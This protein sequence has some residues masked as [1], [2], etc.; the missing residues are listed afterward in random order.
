MPQTERIPPHAEAAEKSVLGSLLIDK[1][2]FF[3]VSDKIRPDD[4]YY[5]AHK[6]IYAAMLELAA[7]SEPIDVITVTNCLKSRKSLDA[8][9]GRA[10]VV[11]LS[12]DIPTTANAGQ[13]AKIIAE[14][15]VLRSLI[16][17]SADIVEKSYAE[18]IESQKVLDHAEQVIFDIAKG[19]QTREYSRVQEVLEMDIKTI[20]EIEKNGDKY[21]R[22]NERN[23][24]Q[25]NDTD[26]FNGFFNDFDF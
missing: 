21:F 6:E 24:E 11:A 26:G 2:A 9:G 12:Q 10:Y 23:Y 17:A 20:Q 22:N 16:S 13:Y 7:K 1:E 14:K 25:F 4:F 15:S 8:A 19:R 3:K 18:N 5:P